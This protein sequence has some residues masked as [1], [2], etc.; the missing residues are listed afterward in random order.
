M[1]L[2]Y[3]TFSRANSGNITM[4]AWN[5]Y[6]YLYLYHSFRWSLYSTEM[7]AFSTVNRFPLAQRNTLPSAVWNPIPL[8]LLTFV[9]SGKILFPLQYGIL[10]LFASFAM[11]KTGRTFRDCLTRSKVNALPKL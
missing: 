8:A 6:Y 5:F 11:P 10:K 1:D 7:G 2:R 3:L 9:F 4:C